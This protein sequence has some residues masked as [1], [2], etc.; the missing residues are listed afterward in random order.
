MIQHLL[1]Y[2]VSLE[3]DLDDLYESGDTK[4]HDYR[5]VMLAK[6]NTQCKSVGIQVYLLQLSLQMSVQVES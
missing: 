4:E 2:F 6:N 3:G 5:N 1:V